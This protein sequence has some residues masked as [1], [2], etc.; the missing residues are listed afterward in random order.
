ME[1]IVFEDAGGL[2]KPLLPFDV[3]GNALVPDGV[4]LLTLAQAAA[5]VGKGEAELRTF[6]VE[7][8]GEPFSDDEAPL[9]VAADGADVAPGRPVAPAVLERK[10]ELLYKHRYEDRG[11]TRE[12]FDWFMATAE[13]RK[14]SPYAGQIYAELQ[15]RWVKVRGKD[16]VKTEVVPIVSIVGL[17]AIAHRTREFKAFRKEAFEYLEE[18]D[19]R[20]KAASCVVVRMTDGIECE[21]EGRALYRNYYT[22]GPV[23]DRMPEVCLSK[24]A[25]AAALRRAFPQ[26]CGG[27]YIKEEMEQAR[28]QGRAGGQGRRGNTAGSPDPGEILPPQEHEPKSRQSLERDLMRA[29]VPQSKRENLIAETRARYPGVPDDYDLFWVLCWRGAMAEPERWGVELA[30]VN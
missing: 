2:L 21:F 11:F 17:R 15:E 30:S 24:C 23:W 14:L 6:Y 19:L 7:V 16:E 27:L 20:P 18:G 1:K 8:L 29:G 13:E 25:E 4:R 5:R 3:D 26:E 22:P 28:A 12:Q 9:F 10:R